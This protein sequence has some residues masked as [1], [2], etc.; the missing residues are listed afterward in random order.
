MFTAKDILYVQLEES[1]EDSKLLTLG[2][3]FYMPH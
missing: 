2:F 3:W 1:F